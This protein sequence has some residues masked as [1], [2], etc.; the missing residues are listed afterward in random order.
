METLTLVK[1]AK[2]YAKHTGLTLSTVSTYAAN[3]GAFFGNLE[4]GKSCTVA[5]FN[6]VL[7]WFSNGWP[8]DLEWPSDIPRPQNE[9]EVA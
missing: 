1:L 8:S 7:A 3:N 4:A 9:S 5:K 2:A 6:V